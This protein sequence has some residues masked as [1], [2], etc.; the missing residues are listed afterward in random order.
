MSVLVVTRDLPYP[1]NAGDRVVTHGFLRALSVRGHAVH[2]L[3]YGGDDERDRARALGDTCASV[4]LAANGTDDTPATVRKLRHWL[5]GR[6][7]VM[8]MFDSPALRTG[9]RDRVR[10]LDP[11]VVLA[12]HPYVAQVFRDEEVRDAVA[13]ADARLV[14]NAHVVEYD[15]HE[16]YRELAPPRECAELA[17]EIPLLRR[18]ELAAYRASDRT[19]VL[20]RED[21]AELDDRVEDVRY[22]PVGLPVAEYDALTG[23]EEPRLLFFGSYEWFPN[24]DAAAWLAEHFPKVRERR[25]DAELVLAGRDAPE[26]VR[27]L[28]DRPGVS[29]VGEVDDLAAEVSRAAVVVAPLRVGGGT[30]LKILES[31]AWG[32]SV[33]TTPAGFEGVDAR[34][35]EDLLVADDAASFV[36]GVVRLLDSPAERRRIGRNARE[37][38]AERYSIPR[39]GARLER[40]LGLVDEPLRPTAGR[41]R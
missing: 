8:G 16:R 5:S 40:N 1:P 7:D 2:L 6:S 20:G 32:A 21:R 35:G 25:P 9:V 26:S 33:V 41:P 30:R 11:D 19:L 37:R 15:V 14:T 31:M 10:A 18:E 12:E 17:A 34:P 38:V 36:A 28:D 22:Q 27:A 24:R 23:S 13:D 4:A 39:A 29:V 3:A